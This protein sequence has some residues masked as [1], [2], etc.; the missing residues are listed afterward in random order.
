MAN[1][2]I[3]DEKF[4]PMYA[5]CCEYDIPVII[6]AGLSPDLRGVLLEHTIPA[7]R[8]AW[9]ATSPSCAFF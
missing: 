3:S 1:C 4:Y 5:L 2:S 7:T 8:T 6:T 9:P